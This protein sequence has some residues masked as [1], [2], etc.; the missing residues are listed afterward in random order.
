MD[1]EW[2]VHANDQYVRVRVRI[3]GD[4]VAVNMPHE[5]A[6]QFGVAIV[7]ASLSTR[8]A[9]AGRVSVARI[10]ADRWAI[11]RLRSLA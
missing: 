1:D 10:L 5:V 4:L 11:R 6:A 8:R 2:S 7:R 3:G 9:Q